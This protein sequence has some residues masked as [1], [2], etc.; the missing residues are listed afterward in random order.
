MDHFH[1]FSTKH[2]SS[3]PRRLLAQWFYGAEQRFELKPADALPTELQYL[4]C[5]NIKWNKKSGEGYVFFII[6]NFFAFLL[7]N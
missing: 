6:L 3:F 4:G 1:H 5:D 7:E 2:I